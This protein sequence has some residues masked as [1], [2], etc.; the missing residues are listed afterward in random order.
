MTQKNIEDILK[1]RMSVYKAGIKVGFWNDIDKAGAFDMMN[2]IFPK[3]GQIAY[4][5]LIME[6]MHKEHSM[7]TGGAY[8][9]FKMPVQVEKE[10]MEYLKKQIINLINI[11]DDEDDYLRIMDTI[12]TDHCFSTVN[13]G[14]FQQNE[15]D[16]ILRLCASHYRFSFLNKIKAYPFFE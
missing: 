10:V 1:M 15:I 14:A 9:L 6:Y 3:S 7:L 4:Y 16:S 2:Y 12:S 13:V 11:V 8:F 5:N